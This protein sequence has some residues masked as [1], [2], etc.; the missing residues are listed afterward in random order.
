MQHAAPFSAPSPAHGRCTPETASSKKLVG[1]TARRA[2]S[3]FPR[4]RLLGGTTWQL[5]LAV[6]PE[7]GC[8]ERGSTS[9]LPA[10]LPEGLAA[11]PVGRGERRRARR[12]PI[13]QRAGAGSTILG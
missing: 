6:G 8:F 2:S 13:V 12:D 10:S 1:V 7:G 3:A 4:H 11:T 9:S 5:I